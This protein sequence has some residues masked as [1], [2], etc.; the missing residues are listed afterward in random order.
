MINWAVNSYRNLKYFFICK[1]RNISYGKRIIFGKNIT[2]WNN[3]NSLLKFG[4]RCIIRDYSFFQVQEK[5]EII[6]GDFVAIG[7]FNMICAKERIE[8]GSFTRIGAYVQIIDNDHSFKKNKLIMKQGYEIAPII[9]GK[10]VWIGSG[11]KILKGVKIGN[12]AVIGANSVVTKDI[13]NN[14]VA[15]G[16]PAKVIKYRK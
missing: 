2:F 6:I 15:I 3:R 12:G 5:G 1:Y 16:S 9:I 8:I 10:D 11:A 14:A 4:N 7:M 13:P